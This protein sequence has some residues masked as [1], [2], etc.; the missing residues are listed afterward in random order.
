VELGLAREVRVYPSVASETVAAARHIAERARESVRARGSFSFVL[1]GGRT[2]Q[3][4]Y[5][6]LA[7]RYRTT[8]PWSAT[9]VFFGDERCVPPNDPESNYALAAEAVLSH[10]PIPPRHVHRLRGELRPPSD[11]AAEYAR[12]IGRLPPPADPARVRFDLVL[13]GVGPDGH[14]ASL[15]PGDRALRERR[16]TV[17]AV[18]RSGQPPYVPRLTLTFPALASSREVCFLVSGPEKAAAV[19][20]I[21]RSFPEGDARVPASLVRTAGTAVWFLDRAAASDL[22]PGVRAP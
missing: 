14:T 8:F 20:S 19:A 16:R 15:F 10:V 22:P 3:G 13:L 7:R 18:R 12:R 1:A 4:L 2:P 6:L 9:E 11:A 5:R 17:V 21:F